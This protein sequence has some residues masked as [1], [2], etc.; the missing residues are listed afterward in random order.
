MKAVLSIKDHF[1]KKEIKDRAS[2][3]LK[4]LNTNLDSIRKE[5]LRYY[6]RDSKL[7]KKV[8]VSPRAKN[9]IA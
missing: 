2:S 1:I 9:E 5:R 8:D 7:D 6:F 3:F 4:T